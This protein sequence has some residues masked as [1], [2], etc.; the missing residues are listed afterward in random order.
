M[1]TVHHYAPRGIAKGAQCLHESPGRARHD[2]RGTG[3]GVAAQQLGVES[4]AEHALHAQRN[5]RTTIRKEVASLPKA[6]VRSE[7]L[8][9]AS[10]ELVE[11]RASDLLFALDDPADCHRKR[12]TESAD[13]R[14]PQ[15][16]LRLVVS[17]TP[18][19]QL[20]VADRRLEGWRVP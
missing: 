15:R 17:G 2:G 10:D 20:A 8:S 4:H 16:D 6:A 3:M 14:K 7:Q 18:R 1:E 13:R 9:V 19:E 5:V 11:V 12:V